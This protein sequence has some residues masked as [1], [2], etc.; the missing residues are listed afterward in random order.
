MTMGEHVQ[1]I[2]GRLCLVT[3]HA[4]SAELPSVATQAYWYCTKVEEVFP[5]KIA[6]GSHL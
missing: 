1:F 4:L 6:I 5:A 3:T 2:L